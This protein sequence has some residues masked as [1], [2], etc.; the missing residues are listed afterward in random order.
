MGS[1]ANFVQE[2]ARSS[3]RRVAAQRQTGEA[4][5]YRAIVSAAKEKNV[6]GRAP[7]EPGSGRP[8]PMKPEFIEAQAVDDHGAVVECVL[9]VE[10]KYF[11]SA[12]GIDTFREVN[13]EWLISRRGLLLVYEIMIQGDRMGPRK[14]AKYTDGEPLVEEFWDIR[15]V[16]ANGGNAAEKITNSAPPEAGVFANSSMLPDGRGLGMMNIVGPF[17]EIAVSALAEPWKQ[18]EFQMIVSIHK[19]RQQEEAA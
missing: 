15:V 8:H 19:A 12:L 2:I 17:D 16:M 6:G 18:R 9:L 13:D 5:Q 4:L 1:E 7:H 10:S 11:G 3:K 14:I